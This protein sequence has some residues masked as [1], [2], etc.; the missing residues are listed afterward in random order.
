MKAPFSEYLTS[1]APGLKE[2]ITLLRGTYD[3][4]SI[5]ATDSR[6]LQINVSQGS[7]S[8][9][10]QT[11]TT[12]RG[13]VVRVHVGDHYSEYSLNR[14]DPKDPSSAYKKITEELQ[15]QEELLKITGSTSYKTGTLKDEP[16]ELFVEMETEQLPETCDVAKLISFMTELSDKGMKDSEEA[17]DIRVRAQSTHICKM[18]LSEHRDLRQSYVYSEGTIIPIVTDGKKTDFGYAGVSGICGPELFKGL[19]DCLPGRGLRRKEI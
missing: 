5:L 15:K 3:Y 10:G 4:V 9:S 8:V 12:E 18:F 13:I 6:G 7:K 16:A 1:I 11:L 19:T 17:T 2:L 14:F